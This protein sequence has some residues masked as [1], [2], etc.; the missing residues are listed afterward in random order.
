MFSGMRLEMKL[1]D[2]DTRINSFENR[3]KD[4]ESAFIQ[5]AKSRTLSEIE[6]VKKLGKE[7]YNLY[8]K[9]LKSFENEQQLLII[10][11]KQLQK[12]LAHELVTEIQ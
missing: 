7:H 3:K 1:I 6:S 8:Q 11:K 4:L 5:D 2:L 9:I 12:E 10:Q